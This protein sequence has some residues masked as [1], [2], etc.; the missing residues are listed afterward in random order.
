MLG[1]MGGEKGIKRG[2]LYHNGLEGMGHFL[3]IVNGGQIV[4]I[5]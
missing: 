3:P 1:E 4:V 5:T 2:E